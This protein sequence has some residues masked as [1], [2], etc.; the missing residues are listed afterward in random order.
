MLEKKW[1]YKSKSRE[2]RKGDRN[3]SITVSIPTIFAVLEKLIIWI[4]EA[5]CETQ[6]LRG[7]S[8]ILCK[9]PGLD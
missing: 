2:G 5:I 3:R 4:A 6:I 9:N 7:M 8:D 1:R